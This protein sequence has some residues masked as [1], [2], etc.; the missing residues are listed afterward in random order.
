MI[1]YQKLYNFLGAKSRTLFD[2]LIATESKYREIINSRIIYQKLITNL[3]MKWERRLITT[4]MKIPSLEINPTRK[5]HD[6]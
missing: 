4:P 1:T 6:L 2:I 5:T 3:K